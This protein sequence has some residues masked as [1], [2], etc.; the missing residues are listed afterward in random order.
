MNGASRQRP[1]LGRIFLRRLFPAQLKLRRC[2]H[3]PPPAAAPA[4]A[5]WPWRH[6][7]FQIPPGLMH[8]RCGSDRG[9]PNPYHVS[10]KSLP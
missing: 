1:R 6:S 2:H 5:S 9:M 3:P 10:H 4:S 7:P 8:K